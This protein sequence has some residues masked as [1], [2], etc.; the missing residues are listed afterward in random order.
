[1]KA[2]SIF[3]TCVLVLEETTTTTF[4]FSLIS[5]SM[6]IRFGLKRQRGEEIERRERFRERDIGRMSGI[7]TGTILDIAAIK[8][9]TSIVNKSPN[10]S[11]DV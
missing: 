10:T 9:S 1:M 8:R 4:K 3:I 11:V 6:N 2:I 7:W 5:K